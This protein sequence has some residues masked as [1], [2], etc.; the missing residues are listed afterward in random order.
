[1]HVNGRISFITFPV[2]KENH[3]LQ[4]APQSTFLTSGKRFLRSLLL[5][6]LRDCLPLIQIIVQG[7]RLLTHPLCLF[8]FLMYYMYDLLFPVS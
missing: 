7:N 1:M 6:P 2:V 8:V 4:R 3:E 5:Q